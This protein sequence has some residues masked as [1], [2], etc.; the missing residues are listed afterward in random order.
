MLLLP[1]VSLAQTPARQPGPRTAVSQPVSQLARGWAAHAEGRHDEAVRLAAPLVTAG[2]PLSHDALALLIRAESAQDNRTAALTAYEQWL[3]AQGHE[4]RFLLQ[5]IAERVLLELSRSTDSAI[6]AAAI[7]RLLRSGN[8]DVAVP[9]DDAAV[10]ARAE[11]GDVAAQNQIT[12]QVESGQLPVRLYTVRALA[13]RGSA[14]VPA[15][16]KILASG[17]P[18]VKGAAADAL[19]DIGSPDAIAALQAA[20][21]DRDPYARLKIAVALARAGDADALATVTTA[22]TS[23]VG[24]IRVMAAEAFRD[25]PTDASRA[26]LRSALADPNPLTRARAASL[27]G[28]SEATTV[29]ADLMASDNPTVREEAARAVEDRTVDDLALLRSMLRSQDPW[30]QLYAAGAILRTGITH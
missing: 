6:R 12:E 10:G 14:A 16:T 7:A 3:K 4:D 26:A 20:R 15:L 2:G 11:A 19:G 30:A 25:N 5:P 24:D 23:Q 29:L 13:A 21:Q 18:D 22:L 27:L 9:N 8:T 17:A 1:A 28:D